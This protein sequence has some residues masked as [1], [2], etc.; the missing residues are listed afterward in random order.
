MRLFQ[1]TLAGTFTKETPTTDFYNIKERKD[2]R[3]VLLL[4]FL[5]N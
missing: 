3:V 4:T 5:L 1:L 2:G